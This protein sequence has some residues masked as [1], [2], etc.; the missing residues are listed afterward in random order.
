MQI[1]LIITKPSTKTKRVV[2]ISV[3]IKVTLQPTFITAC[4][5]LTEWLPEV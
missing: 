5:Y 3:I 4:T 1:T 2:K